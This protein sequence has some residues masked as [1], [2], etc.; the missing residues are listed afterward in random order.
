MLFD[1]SSST[2]AARTDVRY[3]RGVP[4][5]IDEYDAE[6]LKP[7]STTG[8]DAAAHLHERGGITRPMLKPSDPAAPADSRRLPLDSSTV[9]GSA[10]GGVSGGE[11]VLEGVA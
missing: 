8:S 4:L 11:R 5:T 9:P 6:R 7:A 3:T 2:A 1:A 10:R